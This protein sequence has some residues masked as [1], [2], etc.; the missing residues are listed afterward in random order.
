MTV[1]ETDRLALRTVTPHDVENLQMIFS[2]P[3]AMRFMPGTRNL[4]DTIEWIRLVLKSYWEHGFGPWAVLL[5]DSDEFIGY[6]GLYFQK[7]VAGRDEVEILYGFV[8]QHW[9]HGYATEAA[10]GTY[11]YATQV[12]RLKRLISLIDPKN[13]GSIRVAEKVGLKRE[14]QVERWSRQMWI[15]SI[16]VW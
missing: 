4:A 13:T 7:N 2:D 5:K 16:E 3:E 10:Q 9:N 8:R 12:L 1:F 6:C 14:K 11:R 15:F